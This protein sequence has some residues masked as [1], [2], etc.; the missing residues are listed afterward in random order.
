MIHSHLLGFMHVARVV[1]EQE[2]SVNA[3]AAGIVPFGVVDDAEGVIDER[4]VDS[5]LTD[6]GVDKDYIE[7]LQRTMA[8]MLS[9]RAKLDFYDNMKALRAILAANVP[10]GLGYREFLDQIGRSTAMEAIGL[11]GERP[12]YIET[13]YRTNYGS[14]HSAGRWKS[15]QA[16]PLVS[17]LRY[18]AVI[19]DR[20]TDDICRPL[21]GVTKL[22]TDPFWNKYV[23]PNHFSC[24]SQITE[25][26]ESY[27]ERRGIKE[28]PTP[29]GLEVPKEFQT[30]P[31]QSDAWMK[32]TKGMKER[33]IEYES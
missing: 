5:L 22:K 6:A 4:T 10:T 29:T 7:R 16:S 12:Y 1:T 32:S 30:N 15:A 14:A 18:V 3:S 33:L 20:T 24:R 19:D 13:V 27:V 28:T 2:K 31:G 11:A 17:M 23:P 8:P 21:A 9:D 26:T 25:F